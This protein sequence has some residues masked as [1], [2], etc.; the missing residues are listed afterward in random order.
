MRRAKLSIQLSWF[1]LIHINL[2]L[3][4]YQNNILIS[5]EGALRRP[6]TYDNHPYIHPIHK[7]SLII[8][9]GLG[10]ILVD[11]QLPPM[12]TYDYQ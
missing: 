6:K 2:H 9:T 8:L 4:E 7:A 12:T 11:L 10:L 1:L 5:T 3:S